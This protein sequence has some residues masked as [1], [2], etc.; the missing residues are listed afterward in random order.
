MNTEI[1][2]T[3]CQY[4]VYYNNYKVKFTVI[5]I[6]I[7]SQQHLETSGFAKHM[8]VAGHSLRLKQG[9]KRKDSALLVEQ[10]L[11][12]MVSFLTSLYLMAESVQSV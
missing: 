10:G 3:E 2:I 11:C 5:I 6:I 9:S 12:P 7:C 8:T 1:I 4:A